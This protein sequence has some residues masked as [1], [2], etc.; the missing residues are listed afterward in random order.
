[1]NKMIG[2][3]FVGVFDAKVVDDE[4]KNG[5]VRFMSEEAGSV[6]LMVAM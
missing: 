4:R 3:L 6:C 2:A 5:A 1:M